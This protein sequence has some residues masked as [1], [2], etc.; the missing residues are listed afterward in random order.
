M[1]TISQSCQYDVKPIKDSNLTGVKKTSQ[2]A[3]SDMKSYF[4][5]FFE[6]EG[7]RFELESDCLISDSFRIP[8]ENGIPRFTPSLS[9]SS[10]NFSLLR[11]KHATLQLDSV[12]GTKDRLQTILSR[13]NWPQEFFKNKT[14][15]ECGCGAG[16]DTEILLG[17]GASVL[18]IDIAGLDTA[19]KNVPHANVQFVQADITN[20]PLKRKAFDI[21]FCHRVLQHTP[22]PAQ[23]LEAILALVKDDGAVF[24]HTYARSFIQMFRWKYALRPITTRLNPEILY[25]VIDWYSKSVFKLTTLLNRNVLTQYLTWVCI[26]FLNYR[27]QEAF[28]TKTDEFVLE[29]GI[30]D[31]FDAL[32]PKYDNPLPA[33]RLRKIAARHL[34]S[35]YEVIEQPT[36]TLLRTKL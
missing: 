27:H 4:V 9:Y 21:V 32:S 1:K 29:L 35:P 31:T 16:P 11:D 8:I 17:L 33:S 28:K 30:H 14:V 5:E 13:T 25:A 12:N 22:K 15:L 6:K 10:G 34:R 36:I 18:A 20:L 24:V 2:T 26:P 23:T 3:P 19:K 7:E